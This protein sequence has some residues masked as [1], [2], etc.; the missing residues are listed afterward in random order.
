VTRSGGV[1][2]RAGSLILPSEGDIVFA[3]GSAIPPYNNP[4]VA[5]NFFASSGVSTPM[6]GSSV[7][8]MAMG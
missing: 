5:S 6:A 2:C 3:A 7:T 1:Y 8:A 4:S